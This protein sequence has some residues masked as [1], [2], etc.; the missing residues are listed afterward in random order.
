MKS[1]AP[2]ELRERTRQQIIDS[3]GGWSGTVVAAVPPVVFVAVNA[4][5]QLR[6][7]I[8]AAVAAGVLMTGYRLARRQSIQQAATGLFSVLVAALIAARTGQARG[9]FL[10]GIVGSIAYGAV[11]AVSLLLRR[12]L[13]GLAWEFLDPSPLPEGTRWYRVK[14]LRRAYDLA[15]SAALVMFAARAIVQLSLFRSNQTGWL[16][17][18]KIAM[19]F[20]LYLAVIGAAFWVVRRARQQLPPLPVAERAEPDI[21]QAEPRPVE[22]LGGADRPAD[23]RLGLGQGDE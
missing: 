4:L 6:T 8:V 7:A 19:G 12:P 5:A 9:F 15:T 23:R 21:D 16:A 20:P 18:T 17:V 1:P 11:F 13:V 14:A 2:D 22:L 3:M 10:L